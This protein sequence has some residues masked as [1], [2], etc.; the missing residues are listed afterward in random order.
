M[1]LKLEEPGARFHFTGWDRLITDFG[2]GLCV[3]LA[4][5][6]AFGMAI[7]GAE[8]HR[9]DSWFELAIGGCTV[10]YFV[11]MVRLHLKY[12][13]IM[14]HDYV[15]SVDGISVETGGSIR[16]IPWS[17]VEVAEYMPVTSVFRLFARGE[18]R[19]I[20]LFTLTPGSSQSP[21]V[22]RNRLAEDYIRDGLSG[23]LKTKWVPW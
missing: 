6:L 11:L 5:F 3:L 13:Y 18:L 15:V 16:F 8:A 22:K 20:V 9:R 17:D 7:M 23:R 14:K 19:P 4:A 1:N 21:L 12:R 10:A 2:T